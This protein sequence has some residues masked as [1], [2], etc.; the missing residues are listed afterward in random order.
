MAFMG[1]LIVVCFVAL[2]VESYNALKD[3]VAKRRG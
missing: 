1:L 3:W 2:V